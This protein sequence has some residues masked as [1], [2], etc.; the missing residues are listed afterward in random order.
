MKPK[1]VFVVEGEDL[2]EKENFVRL[3]YPNRKRKKLRTLFYY[4]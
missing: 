3:K 1:Y 4:L 2:R